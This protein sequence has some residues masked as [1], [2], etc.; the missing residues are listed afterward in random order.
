MGIVKQHIWRF[1]S[2]KGEL[3]SILKK[4]INAQF[5]E[6]LLYLKSLKVFARK[7]CNYIHVDL[8]SNKLGFKKTFCLNVV[9]HTALRERESEEMQD[10]SRIIQRD[11]IQG[12]FLHLLLR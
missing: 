5:D 2:V 7:I 4:Y 1:I 12:Q 6:F 11:I 8:N 9:L 3:K 10:E